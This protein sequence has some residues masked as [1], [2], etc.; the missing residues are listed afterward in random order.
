MVAASQQP[1][2]CKGLTAVKFGG[3]VS[4]E[5]G[6]WHSTIRG[7]SCRPP[8]FGDPSRFAF[9]LAASK[10]KVPLLKEAAQDHIKTLKEKAEQQSAQMFRLGVA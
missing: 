8:S 4:A 6:C 5:R 7:K 3:V 2:P 9:L 1:R 10:V